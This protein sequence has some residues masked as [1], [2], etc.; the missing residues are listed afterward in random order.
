MI[1]FIIPAYNEEHELPATLS[2]IRAAASGAA[3][4]YEIIVVD[5]A[6]ATPDTERVAG[7]AGPRIRYVR[8][9]RPGLDWARNRGIVETSGEVVA[10]T[11]DD[12]VVDPGWPWRPPCPPPGVWCGP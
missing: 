9:N 2:A 8:E 10:F 4:P 6:S 7:E 3:Q 12:C 1:S 11:D 5:N